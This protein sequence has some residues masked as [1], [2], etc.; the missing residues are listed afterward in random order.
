[1]RHDDAILHSWSGGKD[2][3]MAL[4]H[5]LA[6][7]THSVAA[8]LTTVTEGYDRIS[9]HGV[10]AVLLRQQAAALGLPL[11][12]VTIPP[13]ADNRTYEERMEAAFTRYRADGVTTVAFGDLFLADIRRYRE[14][15]L[16]RAG[17]MPIFPLWQQDTRDLAYRFIAR[18]FT[19]VLTCVDTRVLD[20]SFAG[21]PFDRTL[22]SDLP[23]GVDPC[24]ENGEFH[25]F[26][27]GGP[28]FRH[29][30]SYIRGEVVQRD[31]WC[32]CDLLP[33]P[34]TNTSPAAAGAKAGIPPSSRDR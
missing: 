25:T 26:V 7:Q 12:I 31:A 33:L 11:H 5:L 9:M 18:G 19:A 17:M 2:S 29:D 22:L 8:L 3:C 15:W 20:R 32:F 6:D 4:A 30:V 34:D 27:S 1:M 13:H 28:I 23:P 10:R 24:G 21:R 14:A 16:A